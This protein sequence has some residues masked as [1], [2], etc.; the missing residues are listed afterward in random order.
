MHG[1]KPVLNYRQHHHQSYPYIKGI[2]TVE[3]YSAELSVITVYYWYTVQPTYKLS[4]TVDIMPTCDGELRRRWLQ[5]QLGGVQW[6]WVQLFAQW[7]QR[8]TISTSWTVGMETVDGPC[9]H[10]FWRRDGFRRGGIYWGIRLGFGLLF[11]FRLLL[12]N[13]L[14]KLLANK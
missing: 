4:P 2:H 14:T 9:T 10:R 11:L 6:G 7:V 13:S 5:L 8:L 3:Q 1:N 12:I